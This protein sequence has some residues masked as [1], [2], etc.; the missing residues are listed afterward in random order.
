MGLKKV[1]HP[2]GG[3]K[4]VQQHFKD[5]TNIN[6]I[7]QK[8]LTSGHGS[9][10][11]PGRPGGRE[12]RFVNLTG[13]TYHEML[14]QVQE[15]QGQFAGL[16]SR[17]RKRFANNPQMLLKFLEDPKNLQEAINLGLIQEDDLPE[18]RKAQLDL[19]REAEAKDQEE[20]R[21]W[22]RNKRA[23]SQDSQYEP[24][25]EDEPE[26]KEPPKKGGKRNS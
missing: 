7:M 16:P 9:I 13:Q 12:P 5:K 8:H 18:D 17:V 21:E 26:Q 25:W 19:V 11:P 3:E 22:Q 6:T 2:T 23:S 24:P 20:F 4:I 1:S 10:Q 14:C 15:V